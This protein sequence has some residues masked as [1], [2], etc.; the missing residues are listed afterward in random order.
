MPQP[1]DRDQVIAGLNEL[2]ATELLNTAEV[3]RMFGVHHNTAAA[4]ARKGLIPS[5]FTPGGH[6][7]F[8][9]T[10]IDALLQPATQDGAS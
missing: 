3:A 5:I 2:T 9:K 6:R 8:H 10:D 7:R 1:T 4:W